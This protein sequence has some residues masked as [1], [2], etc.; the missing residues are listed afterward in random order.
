MSLLRGTLAVLHKDLLAELRSRERLSPMVF[1]VL[2]TL[3]V[4][5]FAFGLGGA[6]VDQIGAGVLWSAYVFASVLGLNRSFLEER[7]NGCL[8]G[9]LLAPLD[10]AAVYLAKMLG[11]L[12]FLLIVEGLSLPLFM[13]FFN[14]GAGRFL[15]P[16]SILLL[17]GAAALAAVGTLFAALS[18]N[19]RLRELLLPLLLLPMAL[20]AVI[21]CVRGSA[22]AL[23]GATL[24]ALLPHFQVLAVYILVFVTLSLLLFEHV[25]EE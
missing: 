8:D 14:V 24:T 18:S 9:L 16:L 10:P 15:V 4:F 25:I 3:L 6:A 7:D 17:L 22:A 13:L 21:P 11:N 23:R 5:H 2:L 1:F 19:M 12:V 20:P